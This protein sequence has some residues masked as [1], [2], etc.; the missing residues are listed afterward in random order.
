MDIKRMHPLDAL[1]H[2]VTVIL[3]SHCCI[4]Y[5]V[6]NCRCGSRDKQIID[7]IIVQHSPQKRDRMKRRR[8]GQRVGEGGDL[9]E[10][11]KVTIITK[12]SRYQ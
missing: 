11:H 9:N 2:T 12:A 4:R 7:K 8:E 3:A 1:L 5:G 10:K 6:K